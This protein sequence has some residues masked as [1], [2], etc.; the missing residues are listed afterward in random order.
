MYY[1]CLCACVRLCALVCYIFF[2]DCA[3]AF[4]CVHFVLAFVL[5]FVFLFVCA[6]LEDHQVSPQGRVEMMWAFEIVAG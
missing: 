2:G 4:V 6:Q 3:H 5:V 1:A